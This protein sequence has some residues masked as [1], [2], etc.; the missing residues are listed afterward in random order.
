MAQDKYTDFLKNFANNIA[1]LEN[2]PTFALE[3]I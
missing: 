3:T 1:G 2:L